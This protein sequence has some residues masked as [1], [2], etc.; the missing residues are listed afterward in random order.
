MPAN[1]MGDTKHLHETMPILS[2][3]EATAGQSS[4]HRS[5]TGSS[6]RESLLNHDS[7]TRRLTYRAPTVEDVPDEDERDTFLGQDGSEWRGRASGEAIVRREIEELEMEEPDTNIRQSAW[8]KRISNLSQKLQMPFR[9][10]FRWTWKLR[11]L[12]GFNWP[13]IS[14]D[15]CLILARCFFIILVMAVVYILFISDLFAVDMPKIAGQIFDPESVRIHVQSSVDPNQIRENLKLLT[16]TD[17]IAGTEGDYALVQYMT[18]FFKNYLEDTRTDEY[19][20]YMNYP[21]AGG[22]KVE[23]LNE[24]GSSKWHAK[25]EEDPVYVDPP[26]QQTLVFHGHSKSGNVTGPLIYANYGSGQ[27]FKTLHDSGIN[28]TGAIALIRHHGSQG[29]NS[30]KVK[31]ASQAGFLGCITYSDP[32]DDGF[33]KGRVAPEGRFMPERG[34]QRGGVSITS[35]V[36]GDVLTP[37]WASVPGAQRISKESNSGLVS[38]PSIPLSWGDAQHLLKAIRGVGEASPEGWKGGIPNVEYWTGNSSSPNVHLLNDQDEVEQ[39]PIWNVLGRINGVEQVEKSIIIG[40]HR[41][42]W[43]YG[44]ADPGSGT[45][46]MMEIIRIFGDL[47][48]RGWRPLRTIE[49]ASWDGEQYNL[50]GS[51]EWVEDHVEKLRKDAFVYLNVGSAVSGSNFRASGSPVFKKSLMEVLKRTSD[52]LK[53]K[54]MIDLW[55]EAG[56]KLGDINGRSDYLPFQSMAGTSSFDMGFSDG[57]YPQHS[58]YDNFEWLDTVGDPGFVYHKILA[59]IWALLILEYADKLVLPFDISAYSASLTQSVIDLD[60]WAANKGINQ[61]GNTPWSIEPL[62]EAVLQLAGD[63][64]RFSRWEQEWNAVVYGG[65]GY[66]TPRM[67]EHRKSYNNRMANF[68]THLLDLDE[69]GGIPNRTQFKHIVYGPPLESEEHD[70]TFP[71]IRDAVTARDWN[72]VKDQVEKAARILVKASKKLN[73]NS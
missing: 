26:R 17:H 50:L 61:D 8:G 30:L 40:N 12:D 41:D 24:D 20:V 5:W 59:Q 42:A 22:R 9:L 60:T 56:G 21:K 31:A 23:I 1:A 34:V 28:T 29:D 18:D 54:T 27:D 19:G 36:I 58:A 53:N 70:A 52:P 38:I 2:Y 72:L 39:Q 6:E 33:L 43:H 62:R 51:T 66:E 35:Q 13:K 45:A 49:F 14:V 68:E 57:P 48:H 47:Y 10:P 37:G 16:T 69:G 67:A 4:R 25:I 44:A 55:E 65:G 46:I 7:Q 63:S 15:L 32:S 73:G 64:R 71:A 3:E 11:L